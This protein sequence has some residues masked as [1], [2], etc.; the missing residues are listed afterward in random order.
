MVLPAIA[1]VLAHVAS[2]VGIMHLPA[3]ARPQGRA[4]HANALQYVV[5]IHAE[6]KIPVREQQVAPIESIPDTDDAIPP[7]TVGADPAVH[8]VGHGPLA[9]VAQAQRS[10]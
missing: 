3:E 6:V 7:R 5:V 2:D 9:V 1:R 8:L 10:E 4:G